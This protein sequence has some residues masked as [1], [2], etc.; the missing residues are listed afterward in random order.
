M[1]AASG[2]KLI[3]I[4]I[5]P[6]NETTTLWSGN[7]SVLT[8]L[9]IG[10]YTFLYNY[11]LSSTVGTINSAEPIITMQAPY[12]SPGAIVLVSGVKSGLMGGGVQIQSIMNNVFIP[13]NNTPIYLYLALE[14]T[15]GTVWGIQ[16]ANAK[17][18]KY[19]NQISIIST[20]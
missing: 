4:P 16:L 5:K 7:N 13:T 1:S 6:Q 2:L 19:Y 12:G 3:R 14:I 9:S 10:S 15:A 8:T 11:G 17:Y 18:T 20:R